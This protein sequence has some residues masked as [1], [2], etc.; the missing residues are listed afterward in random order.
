MITINQLR[1]SR[2][3]LVA[4]TASVVALVGTAMWRHFRPP[5]AYMAGATIEDLRRQAERLRKFDDTAAA[6]AAAQ[7]AALRGQLWTDKQFAEWKR[8]LP[9]R[10]KLQEAQPQTKATTIARRLVL[11]R[12]GATARDWREVHDFLQQVDA[13]PTAVLHELK[14]ATTG[15]ASRQFQDVLMVVDLSFTKPALP[16]PVP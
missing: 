9:P 15:P 12:D 14:L 4:L 16:P 13:L 7:A 1:V 11:T 5:L 2:R 10:W 3:T 6:A 8:T